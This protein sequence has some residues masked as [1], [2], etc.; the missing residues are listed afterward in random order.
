M[1]QPRKELRED[2]LGRGSHSAK[3]QLQVRWEVLSAMVCSAI[4]LHLSPHFRAT[5]LLPSGLHSLL[6]PTYFSKQY[7]SSP[8]YSF[9]L[10]QNPLE[11][12]MPSLPCLCANTP[13]TQANS[14]FWEKQ[15]I[16][17]CINVVM[18]WREQANYRGREGGE[19]IYIEPHIH[20]VL[21]IYIWPSLSY[22]GY[23]IIYVC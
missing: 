5:P 1:S 15:Y 21:H 19:A 13:V 22:I 3:L 16:G 8:Q 11:I 23:Y 12:L 9:S 10:L 18:D 6:N 14:K 2:I 4:C 7:D 17:S 20:K